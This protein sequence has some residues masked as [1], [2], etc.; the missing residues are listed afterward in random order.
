MFRRPKDQNVDQEGND[1]TRHFLLLSTEQ[2][3]QR[4]EA[5]AEISVGQPDKTR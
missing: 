4:R 1:P 3:T 5:K 2:V